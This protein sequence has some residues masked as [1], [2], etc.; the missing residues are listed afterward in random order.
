MFYFTNKFISNFIKKGEKQKSEKSLLSFLKSIKLEMGM[1]LISIFLKIKRNSV[2]FLDLLYTKSRRNR[3]KYPEGKG[4]YYFLSNRRSRL[5]AKKLAK[6]VNLG[7]SFNIFNNL[8]DVVENIINKKGQVVRDRS[9]IYK[10]IFKKRALLSRLI[11]ASRPK[12]RKRRKSKR[13]N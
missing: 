7:N 10:N 9:L 2:M 4:I 11:N 1:D 12:T 3:S 13:F 6:Y 5:A 8:M